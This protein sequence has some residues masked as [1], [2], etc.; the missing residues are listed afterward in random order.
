MQQAW[1]AVEQ[2]LARR[3]V[4]LLHVEA[5]EELAVAAARLRRHQRM[6]PALA[7][8][9]NAVDLLGKPPAWAVCCG[10]IRLQMAVVGDDADAAT[11]VAQRL[12]RVA[13]DAP[14][15]R[16]QCAAATVWAAA[17]AG[18]VDPRRC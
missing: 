6:E 3:E 4:D 9:E 15:Q 14:R 16:A 11:A 13:V 12:D 17:L 18:R 8:I 7:M 2:V 5:V 10:W 1:T